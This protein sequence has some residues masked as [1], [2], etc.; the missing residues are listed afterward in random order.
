MFGKQ[1]NLTCGVLAFVLALGLCSVSAGADASLIGWYQFEGNANDSS[2]YG[3][4]GTAYGSPVW[5]AGPPSRGGVLQFDGAND[6]VGIGE[7][8]LANVSQF[9]MA[10]WVSAGNASGSGIGLFGQNDV[11]EAGFMN[12]NAEIWTSA[13][14]T[15][16][17]PW[18]FAPLTW[19]HV[20]YVANSTSIKIY[21]DG[22]LAVTGSCAANYGTSTY[23]FNIG[24]GGVWDAAGNWFSGQMDDVRVYNRALSDAEVELL[25]VRYEAIDPVPADG[26][27][28][29]AWV[30]E[31]NVYMMLYYT[32]GP[33]A[34]T[35][36][37]YFSDV[38]Q[39]VIDRDAAHCL[40]SVP[41]W[42]EADPDAFVVGFD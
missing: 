15:T 30:W 5:V 42:P 28:V 6:Y 32:P 13:S 35:H 21:L 40:G 36:T 39:D 20:A 17:T 7:I 3:N 8:L 29:G 38:E 16:T 14:G 1:I 12:G 18:S 22:E 4:H 24:G 2:D 27:S 23:N 19:H 11:I 33:F 26:A 34:T 31:E 9:T 41:P 37:A 10:G 25:A